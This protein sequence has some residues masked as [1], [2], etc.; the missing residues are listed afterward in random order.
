[1]PKSG[2]TREDGFVYYSGAWRSPAA[3]EHRRSKDGV[4]YVR[5]CLPGTN[6]DVG[7][8][9]EFFVAGD[10]LARG[11]KVTKP[12]NINGEHDLHVKC[13]NK[14]FTVQVK[15]AGRNPHTGYLNVNNRGRITSDIIAGV[16][17]PLGEIRYIANRTDVPAELHEGLT[18]LYGGNVSCQS[19]SFS[20]RAAKN[21]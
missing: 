2:D 1:M 17:L 9:I 7:Q 14:W 15:S 20:A 6:S 13:A 11:L 12:L 5:P 21:E 18:V 4:R 19:S 10:L 16:F 3:I 8:A